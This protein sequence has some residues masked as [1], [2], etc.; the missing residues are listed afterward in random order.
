MASMLT[1]AEPSGVESIGGRA[2]K[3]SYEN[4]L[5]STLMFVAGKDAISESHGGDAA[6]LAWSLN[7]D[8]NHI[9]SASHAQ[10]LAPL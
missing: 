5:V 7:V 8:A 6:S 4:D 10:I 2:A 9:R 3:S 1:T